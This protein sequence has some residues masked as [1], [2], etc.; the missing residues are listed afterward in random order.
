MQEPVSSSFDVAG[1]LAW[2]LFT[3][4]VAGLLWIGSLVYF[5]KTE[6]KRKRRDDRVERKQPVTAA[7]VVAKG[8]YEEEWIPTQ[9]IKGR[10]GATSDDGTSGAESESKA[11]RR[12]GRK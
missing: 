1:I 4:G 12:K 10:K 9:H 5:G 2:V 7:P 8:G 3:L 11:R 6:T